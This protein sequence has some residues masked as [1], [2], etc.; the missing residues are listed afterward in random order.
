MKRVI[1]ASILSFVLLF[2]F[3]PIVTQ[4]GAETMNFKLVSMVERRETVQISD[5]EGVYIGVID[6]KGLSMFENGDIATM[7]CRGTFDTKKGFQGYSSLTFE[8]GSTIVLAWKGP[9]SWIPPG[10]KFGGYSG[11]FE[12]AKGTGRFEGIK[13]SGSFTAKDPRWDKDFKAKG[14]TYYEWTGTYTLPSQ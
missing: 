13:G 9:T 14:F 11:T 12:Y 3:G 10:G 8:D 1:V 5:L 7:S 4:A 2:A 6:R